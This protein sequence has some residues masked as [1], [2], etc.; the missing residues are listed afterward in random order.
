M[1]KTGRILERLRRSFSDF[2]TVPL[3]VVIGFLALA[4]AAHA[5]DESAGPRDDWG[6]IWSLLDRYVGNVDSATD[7]LETL[8]GSLITVTSITFSILLL[9]VQ[10]GAS[11]LTSQVFDQYLQRRSNQA[12]FGFFVG[13]SLYTVLILVLT[14]S[15]HRP[16]ISGTIA[17][18]IVAVALC[19]LVTLIY[20][21]VD[22][23]RASSII[24]SIAVAALG[25]RRRQID[26]L[27]KTQQSRSRPGNTTPILSHVNGYLRRVD[28]DALL[29]LTTKD[30]SL[31]IEIRPSLGDYVP[32]HGVLALVPTGLALTPETKTCIRRAL[33]VEEQR[34]LA[35]DAAYGVSQLTIIG[36]TSTS[37]AKSNPSAAKASCQA[38]F[39]LLWQW[40]NSEQLL[41]QRS[42]ESRVFYPDN[43]ADQVFDGFESIL[44]AA[45]ESMQHQTLG[46]VL[47]ALTEGF[48]RLPLTWRDRA[49][50]IFLLSLDGL[51]DHLPTRL[52]SRRYEKV[53]AVLNDD[54]RSDG[55]ALVANGWEKFAQTKGKLHSRGSRD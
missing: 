2:L 22:Q 15:E 54:G 33:V 52:L 3:L 37:T 48:P 11:S 51:G 34:D 30:P 49:E 27:A 17:I 16:V 8:A 6:P 7:L 47:H 9:A 5:I 46:E 14:T 1:Q 26:W 36:W 12:Y 35:Q 38:L 10:Q 53:V 18:I 50:D 31:S 29:R 21:T 28:I 13:A 23:T 20:T 24:Q 4:F 19:A 40:S 44:I 55:A 42:Y 32:L 25:T 39:E 45:S 41:P 43:V